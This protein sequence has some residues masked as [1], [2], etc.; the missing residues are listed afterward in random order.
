M[1]WVVGGSSFV[2]AYQAVKRNRGSAGMDGVKTED[3]PHF[4]TFNWERIRQE[5]LCGNYRPQ[6]VRGVGIPKPNGGTRQLGIPTVIDRVIQQAIHQ[7]LSPIF[8]PLFSELSYGFRKGKTRIKP[9]VKP[10]TTSIRG[11]SG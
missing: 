8:E 4:M 7:T 11:E 2:N 5:L 6:P 3:L 9:L 1:R 10:R